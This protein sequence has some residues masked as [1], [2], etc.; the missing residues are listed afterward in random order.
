MLYFLTD[1]TLKIRKK[2]VDGHLSCNPP[3]GCDISVHQDVGEVGG[4][5]CAPNKPKQT[6]ITTESI[7]KIEMRELSPEK[8]EN[9]TKSLNGNIAETTFWCITMNENQF[10]F[11]IHMIMIEKDLN[12]CD[13]FLLVVMGPSGNIFV[14]SVPLHTFNDTYSAC[15][16][17]IHQ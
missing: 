15:S 12:F 1:E 2:L 14:V 10:Y 6:S 17:R 4:F 16:G 8:Y 7:S 3:P 5:L 11:V 13:C 9:L